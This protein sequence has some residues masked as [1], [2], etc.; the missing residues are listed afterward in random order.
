MKDAQRRLLWHGMLLLILGL[1]TGFAET[2]FANVRMGLPL[3][4]KT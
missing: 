4:W 3:I 1:H 2:S